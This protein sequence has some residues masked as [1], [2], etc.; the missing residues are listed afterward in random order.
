MENGKWDNMRKHV[1]KTGPLKMTDVKGEKCR[2]SK[3]D[4]AVLQGHFSGVG[5]WTQDKHRNT[6]TD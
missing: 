6:K 4:P 1:G 3:P 5:G 2:N